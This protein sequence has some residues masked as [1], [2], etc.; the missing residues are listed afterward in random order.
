MYDSVRHK[1][2]DSNLLV[3]LFFVFYNMSILD[4]LYNQRVWIT[5]FDYKVLNKHLGEKESQEFF[6]FIRDKKYIDVLD[7]ILTKGFSI[8]CKKQIQKIASIKKRV[9]YTFPQE[10]NYILKLLTYLLIRRYDNIFSPNLYSFRANHCVKQAFQRIVATPNIS[11]YYTYKVDISDYFNSIDI[12]ILLQR[13]R[14]VLQD[15]KPLYDFIEALLKNPLVEENGEVIEE[16][17]GVMAGCPIAVFLAN[18]YL[19]DLDRMFA[20][21]DA[22]YCRYSDDII[23]F[24]K[25][26]E[27]QKRLK[28][29]LLASLDTYHLK[30]NT[31]KEVSTIPNEPWTFL[32]LK[33]ANGQIDVSDIAVKKIKAKMRRKARALIRWKNRNNRESIHAVKAFIKAFNKKFYNNTDIHDMTWSRWYFPLIT[34]DKSLKVIDQYM[35]EC[36]RYIATE[37]HTKSQY[38]FRY[39]QMKE[40]GYQSLVN[41]WY[42]VLQK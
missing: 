10:E 1:V 21:E 41:N 42:K 18:V 24:T 28:K 12:N 36:I 20:E 32:G 15:D 16:Q 6:L 40:L 23:I 30:L 9:V 39:S 13:L 27:D 7:Q 22:I 31:A 8:P 34:T 38:S 26:E 4:Y 5:Y 35:Q 25:T 37:T 3:F 14:N 33:Y 11:Q 29:K 2:G 19:L 17:K